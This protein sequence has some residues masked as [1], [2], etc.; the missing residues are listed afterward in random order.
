M[1]HIISQEG[2]AA[3]P[4]KV[5]GMMEWQTPK[6][7]REL[8]GLLGLNGYYRRFVKR[9]GVMGKPVT[10]LLGKDRFEWSESATLAFD[11]LKQAMSTTRVLVLPDFKQQ[12]PT[13]ILED[14]DI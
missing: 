10:D 12:F 1:G 7:I 9:Y 3:D 5:K 8:R 11:Q 2:V 13:F 6:T 14:K 4:E